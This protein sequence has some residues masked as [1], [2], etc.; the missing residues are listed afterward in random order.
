M[1]VQT[2]RIRYRLACKCGQSVL[3]DRSQAGLAIRCACGAELEVPTIRGLRQL[4][5]VAHREASSRWGNRQ[6]LLVIGLALAAIGFGGGAYRQFF[7]PQLPYTQADFE[8]DIEAGKAAIRQAPPEQTFQYW[9]ELRRGIDRREPAFLVQHRV[10]TAENRRWMWV[11][12]ALG[13]AGLT[14]AGASLFVPK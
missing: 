8:R 1:T 2:Q 5:Q 6:A 7:P 13:V 14:V 3:V 4:E 9:E 11:M 10:R 12:Y